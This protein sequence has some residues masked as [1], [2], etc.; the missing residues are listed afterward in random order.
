MKNIFFVSDT[1]FGHANCLK[2]TRKDGSPLRV[3]SSV[4]EMDE[5]MITRWN[6]VVKPNDRIYHCGDVVI[7]KEFLESVMP[8]LNGK[9]VLL[10]GNHDIYGHEEYLKYFEDIRAYK[11]MPEHGLIASHIP[12]YK[13]MLH[14]TITHNIHGHLHANLV[15]ENDTVDKRYIN[16][17]VENINYTPIIL[18]EILKIKNEQF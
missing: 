17:S 11:V 13:D 14:G 5:T 12:V 9:K 7:R 8:R 2:F 4:E 3:F 10:M 16:V 6:S 18:E 1:H 15:M